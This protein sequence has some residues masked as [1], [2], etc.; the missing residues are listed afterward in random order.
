MHFLPES[1]GVFLVFMV[2]ATDDA[3]SDDEDVGVCW[4]GGEKNGHRLG[5]LVATSKVNSIPYLV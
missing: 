3:E 1:S 5:N 4:G 2:R